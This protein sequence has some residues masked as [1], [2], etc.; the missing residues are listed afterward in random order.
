MSRGSSFRKARPVLSR[1]GC[2]AVWR[3]G[4]LLLG[5]CRC[6]GAR[7]ALSAWPAAE[8]DRSGAGQQRE[9]HRQAQRAE[10]CGV[11]TVTCI[12]YNCQKKKKRAQESLREPNFVHEDTIVS[13]TEKNKPCIF[14]L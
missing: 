3:Q 13:H 11:L 5:E 2:G 4:V 1:D 9:G 10:P 7:A 14:L 6:S 8:R 12:S